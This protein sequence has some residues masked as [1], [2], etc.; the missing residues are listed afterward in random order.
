MFL[1]G[2]GA[3]LLAGAENPA[4]NAQKPSI[5]FRYAPVDRQTAYCLPDDPFKSLV[6]GKGDLRYGYDRRRNVYNF[7]QIMQFSLAGMDADPTFEQTI[8]SPGVP[9]VHTRIVR[10][11]AVLELIAFATKRP[12]EG[13]VDNVLAI[14][15]PRVKRSLL[16]AITVSVKTRR[17]GF[18]RAVDGCA[19]F[20][21]D[22]ESAAPFLIADRPMRMRDSGDG[23]TFTAEEGT[24]SAA[25][26]LRMF[27]RF[28]QEGQDLTVLRAGLSDPDGLLAEARAFWNSWSPFNGGVSMRLPGEYNNFLTA[29]ARNILQAREHVDGKLTFQVGPTVYRGLWVVDGNF[30]LEAASYL[31]YDKDVR[32]GLETTWSMQDSSGGIFAGGGKEHWK[33]TAIAMFTM[34]RQA[35]L[36]QDWS[37]FERMRPQVLAGVRFLASLRDRARTDGSVNGRYGLLARGIGDGGIGGTRDEFTN[38]LWAVAG[39]QAV[40]DAARRRKLAGYDEAIKLHAELREAFFRAAR[41]QMR[42]HPDGFEFLPMLAKEDKDWSHADE[43]KR[44]RVQ[45]G[46]WA[47]AQGIFP[48]RV[49][50]RDDPI[51]KGYVSL[52]QACSREEVPTETGWLPHDGLWT[53]DAAFAAH[54][55]LWAGWQDRALALFHGFLNHATPLYVWR[56]EQPLRGALVG[57]YVGDMPHNWA[58][59]ECILFLRHMLALEDGDDLRLM[60]GVGAGQLA[61]GKPFSLTRTPT[62]FGSIDVNLEPARCGQEWRLA[63]R[64]GAGPAPAR[65]VLPHS[66][67]S[68]RLARVDGAGSRVNGRMAEI[69]PES[70]NWSAVWTAAGK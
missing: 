33:D 31:G 5:D 46:Q 20:S 40:V 53:Y 64:R 6:G 43:W 61:F 39:L 47:L 38:T 26:P 66:I 67:G 58:S 4:P 18:A 52:M 7:P 23:F 57:G 24:A 42:R 2:S 11:A 29:C 3:S 15:T 54:A 14:V 19:V 8:E 44:P 32:A 9:V 62:R 41:D 50:G 21:L 1:A 22:A 55:H 34:V 17:Q 25:T 56:E 70:V 37:F 45:A 12:G 59:A 48:G 51:V 36:S 35:E 68:L 49:F 65:V 30:I 13:R 27:F 16:A 10:S 28:P 69:A 63:F 60:E